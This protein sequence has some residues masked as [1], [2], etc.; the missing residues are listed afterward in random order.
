MGHMGLDK[1]MGPREEYGPIIDMLLNSDQEMA[2]RS[3]TIFAIFCFRKQKCYLST[4]I[5]SLII[6]DIPGAYSE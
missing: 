3:T 6:F 4:R 1:S 2:T 5:F